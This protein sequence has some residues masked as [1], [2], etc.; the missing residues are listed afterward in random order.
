MDGGTLNMNAASNLAVKFLS[1]PDSKSGTINAINTST[2][3]VD[4]GTASA[5][6]LV[7]G[8]LTVNLDDVSNMSVKLFE[9]DG[10][11]KV[12]NDGL[13]T[14]DRFNFT[15]GVIRVD[16]E[17]TQDLNVLVKTTSTVHELRIED[18]GIV[19]LAP[20]PGD[21]EDNP[22]IVL[23]ITGALDLGNGDTGR[24]DMTDNALILKDNTT[25]YGYVRHVIINAYNGGTWDEPG[26]TTSKG[27]TIGS[28]DYAGKPV[29]LGCA[30]NGNLLVPFS[31]F[32]GQSVDGSNLLVKWTFQGDADLDGDVDV[33]DLGTTASNW[34]TSGDWYQGD[35][36]YDG[37]IAVND[38]GLVAT[39]W[40]AGVGGPLLVG[41]DPVQGFLDGIEK[42]GLAEDEIAKLMEILGNGGGAA[43]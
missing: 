7:E 15:G 17:G 11:V 40:Q 8:N 4:G 43:L 27:G 10:E 28:G 37:T 2:L 25:G 3:T 12:N 24:L 20:R 16:G 26:I 29:A 33:A 36:D 30:D 32:Q 1:V 23:I 39:N 22:A 18:S 5:D 13:L 14:V 35:F 41:G 19:T 38:L 34:Q 9:G 6:V 21:P 31:S 42:L